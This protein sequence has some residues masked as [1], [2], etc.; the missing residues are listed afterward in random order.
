LATNSHDTGG[1]GF[2]VVGSGP[3]GKCRT[4]LDL[5]RDRIQGFGEALPSSKRSGE[6]CY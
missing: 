6:D 2:A 4:I 5:R 1:G 3:K